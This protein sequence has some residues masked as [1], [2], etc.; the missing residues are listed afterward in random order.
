MLTLSGD[1]SLANYQQVLRTATYD[2]GSQDPD[3]TARLIE[4]VVSD[5]QATSQP[6]TATVSVTPANDTPAVTAANP[7]VTVAEGDTAANSGTFFDVESGDNVQII[8]A[9]IGTITQ[10]SG[11]S[12]SWQPASMTTD[13]PDQ[14][15]TVTITA[16]DRP[17]HLQRITFDLTVDNAASGVD[18]IRSH[19]DQRRVD[20]HSDD[21]FQRPGQRHD[22]PSG[23]STGA[24]AAIR[25][26]TACPGARSCPGNPGSV[27]HVY[28][29]GT[30]NHTILATA[31]D[32]DGTYEA[33]AFGGNAI[34]L[35]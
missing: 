16:D 25:T 12:G 9:S 26:T 18:G 4:F 17:R 33:T 5:G 7:T 34:V 3:P 31:T 20:L 28:V 21:E 6:A 27:T 32:E 8:N 22:Q 2:N 1:D 14:T 15:Q 23:T 19:V 35:G 13:G 10:D 24:T 11:N 29:D 30:K